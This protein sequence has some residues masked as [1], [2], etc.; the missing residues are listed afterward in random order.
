MKFEI[1]EIAIL[2]GPTLYTH[3]IGHE[4]EIVNYNPAE[5]WED[6]VV[7]I[8]GTENLATKALWGIEEHQLKKLLPP[9]ELGSWEALKDIYK[10][11]VLEKI[12]AI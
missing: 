6:Y 1:G 12:D 11:R 7:Y 10:P 4:C 5:N 8:P 9:D 2:Q 3:L